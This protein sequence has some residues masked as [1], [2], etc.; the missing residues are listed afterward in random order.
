VRGTEKKKFVRLWPIPDMDLEDADRH[1]RDVHF[2]FAA[3]TFRTTDAVLAY[4]SNRALGQFELTGG[5]S[6]DP[7]IWRFVVTR[8]DSSHD[9]E[10]SVGWL[11]PRI[12]DLFF[13]DR[14][15]GIG[16]VSSCEVDEQIVVDRRSGQLTSAKYII[17]FTSAQFPDAGA[18]DEYYN[19]RHL[20]AIAEA[21][22]SA[23]GLRLFITN[24]VLQEAETGVRPDGHTEY[25]GGYLPDASVRRFEELWFDSEQDG[26]EFF[27]SPSVL[28]L[29]RDS[30]SGKV[31]AYHVEE[32]CGIDRR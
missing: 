16:R 28:A 12:R 23:A 11:D 15:N 30:P 22:Q 4:H 29:M 27:R 21:A 2:R 14:R 19:S 3:T 32:H 26:R 17:Q 18:F 6:E 8:W 1:Y 20:P 13:V 24:P 25:T 5:F 9:G 31:S 7:D 10:H